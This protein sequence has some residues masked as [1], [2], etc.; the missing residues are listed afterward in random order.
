MYT[1]GLPIF[2][3]EDHEIVRVSPI[4]FSC[5]VQI[6]K[7]AG[8]TDPTKFIQLSTE[9]KYEKQLKQN[10]DEALD[11]KAF[12]APWIVVYKDGKQHCFFGSDRFHHIAHLIGE[13]FT[14]GKK[15]LDVKL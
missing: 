12:G 6:L 15:E 9:E 5:F 4:S 7:T 13:T 1:K 3:E 2:N 10:T 11:L 8:F 14:S